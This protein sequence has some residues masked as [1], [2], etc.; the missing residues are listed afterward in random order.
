MPFSFFFLKKCYGCLDMGEFVFILGIHC[1][2][3]DCLF[4]ILNNINSERRS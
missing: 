2:G 3:Y 4:K 1:Q